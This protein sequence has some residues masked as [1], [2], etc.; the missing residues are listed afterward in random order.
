MGIPEGI[1]S[2]ET[3]G[4]RGAPT[5]MTC[6]KRC[7]APTEG[8]AAGAEG[9]SPGDPA[10][11]TSSMKS[12][13][14]PSVAL[15]EGHPL[16]GNSSYR[17]RYDS[18]FKDI[19]AHEVGPYRD[20]G[21]TNDPVD[22]GGATKW[23]ISLRWLKSV[24]D[25]DGDGYL[26]GDLDHDG[27]VDINDIRALTA[28]HAYVLYH[29][30]WWRPHGYC[31]MPRPVGEKMVDCA[32]NMGTRQAA[33]LLQRGLVALGARLAVDGMIGPVTLRTMR[34]FRPQDVVDAI[35]G[36]QAGFYRTLVRQK[37]AFKKYIKGWLRRAGY[38]ASSLNVVGGAR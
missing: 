6:T 29:D 7:A 23:G 30:R 16:E 5:L 25:L 33:K 11:A 10:K 34:A 3:D 28:E 21:F 22:P 14:L 38:L 26:D 24:G 15:A 13:L 2:W 32:I 9:E 17:L 4:W 27:D 12:P 1:P 8:L 35:C 31:N 19:L 18:V 36:E 20:G 37:P